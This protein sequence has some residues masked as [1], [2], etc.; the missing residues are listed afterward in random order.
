M[1]DS[2][3]PSGE[4]L[5]HVPQSAQH[6]RICLERLILFGEESL[7][8]ALHQFVAYYRKERPHQGLANRLI[9]PDPSHLR[10][11]CAA[12]QRQRLGGLLNCCY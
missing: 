11:T 3:S 9:R 12:L 6:Q 10:N 4:L 1:P 7:Q 8:T 2:R 5:V